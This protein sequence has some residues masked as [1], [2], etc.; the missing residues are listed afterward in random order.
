MVWRVAIHDLDGTE[1]IHSL[2][3]RNHSFI[4]VMNGPGSF[5]AEINMGEVSR[6]DIEPGQSDYR[7]YDD[8]TLYA[9]G[10]IWTAHPDTSI[11]SQKAQLVGNGILSVL[12]KRTVDW[13][14][15]YEPVLESPTNLNTLYEL[16]QE[17]I[18]FDFI[19]RTQAETGGD[20]GITQ[21]AH[22]GD[23][24]LRRRWYCKE[25]G[26]FIFD[27]I[28]PFSQL[29][30]GIDFALTPTLTDTSLREYTTWN[31]SR[32]NDLSGSIVLSVGVY[33]DTLDYEID[34]G[35]TISRA[36]T[37]G[38][39][40]CAPPLG[41]VTDSTALGLYDLLESHETFASEE[42]E[43]VDEAAQSMLDTHKTQAVGSDV[44]Y[45]RSKGPAIG[46]FDVGDIITLQNDFPGWEFDGPVKVQEIEIMNQVPEETFVRVNWVAV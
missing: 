4:H 2:P 7:I 13:E 17:D 35:D 23:S 19:T 40:D 32:G 28:F 43:D 3:I 20:L 34:A 37:T 8:A 27:I 9:E 24:R 18:T 44:W 39:G 16:P 41:D 22:T 42:Q 5:R 26:E 6:A 38:D 31:P 45:E 1:R 33:L 14:A 21:G 15:R 30:N 25:D 11:R 36:H 12:Q 10:R 46:S 29:S